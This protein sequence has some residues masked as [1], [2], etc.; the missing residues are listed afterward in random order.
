MKQILL[1]AGQGAQFVGMGKALYDQYAQVRDLYHEASDVLG[2]DLAKLSFEG[3]E[4]E[5]TRT[6]ICQPALFVHGWAI[7]TAAREKG[8]ISEIVA[9]LGLS[10]GE[11][12][13]LSVAGA[14]SFADGVRLVSARGSLMQEACEQTNGAMAS[15][16]GGAVEDVQALCKEYDIDLANWNCPGQIVI[17]GESEKVARAVE[18]GKTRGFKQIIPLKVAGAYH[19]RLMSAAGERFAEI[20]QQTEIVAP[21][22]PVFTNTTGEQVKTPEEIRV[23]LAKQVANS[24][25]WEA[26][27]R[28]AAKLSPDQWLECGPKKVLTGLARRID[29]EWSVVSPEDDLIAQ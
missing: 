6:A 8:M 15:V 1:F 25:L 2:F 16:I 21:A 19:S 13:A 10:L 14:F 23:A 4:E 7:Y 3:P 28:N 29:K 26:C 9:A 20:L 5:L 18:A 11:L 12:T 24:V 22:L 17:S 27:M